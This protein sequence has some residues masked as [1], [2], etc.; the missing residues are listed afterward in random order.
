MAEADTPYQNRT[1]GLAHAESLW[2]RLKAELLQDGCS[3]SLQDAHD[4]FFKY[5]ESRRGT[6]IIMFAGCIQR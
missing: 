1:G 6:D 5:I 3:M 4:E 2:G